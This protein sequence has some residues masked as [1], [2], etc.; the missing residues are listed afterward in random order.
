[1][2]YVWGGGLRRPF[3]KEAP[4]NDALEILDTTRFGTEFGSAIKPAI[5]LKGCQNVSTKVASAVSPVEF[6]WPADTRL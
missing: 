5:K 4:R 1:M 2:S 3:V 6:C